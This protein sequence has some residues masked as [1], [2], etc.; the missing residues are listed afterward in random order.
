MFLTICGIGSCLIGSLLAGSLFFLA[1]RARA[2]GQLTARAWWAIGLF[3][4]GALLALLGVT[5]N[6]LAEGGLDSM[7]YLGGLWGGMLLG[8]AAILGRMGSS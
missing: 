1:V 2:K 3:P 7:A 8:A 5:I 4:V 6:W